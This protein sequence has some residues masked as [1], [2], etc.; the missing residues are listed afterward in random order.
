[1]KGE[2]S[3]APPNVLAQEIIYSYSLIPSDDGE[4]QIELVP[5]P[6]PGNQTPTYIVSSP[7]SNI[8]G[9]ITFEIF[10]DGTYAIGELKNFPDDIA[11][12]LSADSKRRITLPPTSN[13]NYDKLAKESL[14][15]LNKELVELSLIGDLEYS[16]QPPSLLVYPLQYLI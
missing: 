2:A 11:L 16:L 3:Y 14:T 12:G 6:P 10:D 13:A 15:S 8:E 4:L 9:T 5:S 7:T 1:M